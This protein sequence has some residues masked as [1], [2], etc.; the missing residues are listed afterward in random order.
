M[1][2]F[3]S[4]EGLDSRKGLAYVRNNSTYYVKILDKFCYVYSDFSDSFKQAISGQDW[5][6]VYR[7]A[8]NLKSAADSIGALQLQYYAKCLE[9][10]ARTGEI[11]RI[12]IDKTCEEV[13]RLVKAITN[14]INKKESIP[15][16]QDIEK[17]LKNVLSDL[18]KLVEKC[19]AETPDFL[20]K[21]EVIFRNAN[22]QNLYKELYSTLMH[23]RF[24]DAAKILSKYL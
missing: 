5:E 21:H 10:T 9:D 12:D 16:Q 22:S 7:L 4:I 17:S 15:N 3:T 18:V 13:D 23:Y 6:L 1:K 2:D 20:K 24:P 8:H 11:D 14:L 19:D